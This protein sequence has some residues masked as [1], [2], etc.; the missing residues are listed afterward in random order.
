M[1]LTTTC[2]T[3]TLAISFLDLFVNLFINFSVYFR[4]KTTIKT[5]TPTCKVRCPYKMACL[6]QQSG[7]SISSSLKNGE[8]RYTKIAKKWYMESKRSKKK[9]MPC[10]QIFLQLK[11]YSSTS[12]ECLTILQW[13]TTKT[14]Q[15]AYMHVWHS[16][17]TWSIEL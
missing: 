4:L 11:F 9:V 3:K 8:G 7:H 1:S 16:Y 12:H 15:R 13:V 2:L 14:N 5:Y 6:C 10:T 17:I